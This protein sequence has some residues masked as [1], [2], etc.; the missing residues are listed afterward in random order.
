M[1]LVGLIIMALLF[2]WLA[3]ILASI[4]LILDYEERADFRKRMAP[5][6]PPSKDAPR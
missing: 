2:S 6:E 1:E 4:S 5:S 3:I